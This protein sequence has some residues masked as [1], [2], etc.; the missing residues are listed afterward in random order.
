M[1]AR[2]ALMKLRW[3]FSASSVYSTFSVSLLQ[4]DLRVLQMTMPR[5]ATTDTNVCG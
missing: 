5:T 2:A 3:I 4:F 1:D